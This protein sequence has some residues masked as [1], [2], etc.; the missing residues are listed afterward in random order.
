MNSHA[1]PAAGVAAAGRLLKILYFVLFG[2]VG[3]YWVV[4][5]FVAAG[6]EPREPGL[7]KNI[8][9][10]MGAAVGA[11]VVYLR[12]FLIPAALDAAAMEP[13]QRL[14]RLRLYYI[15]CFVLTEAVA[16]YGFLL[17]LLGG[18]PQDAAL[19]FLAAAGLFLLCYPRLPD[20]G[21]T[22]A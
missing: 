7:V 12:F 4:L 1:P 20:N 8:L 5:E 3:L 11:G 10:G 16:I 21:G 15:L 6:L 13:A 19:F 22:P 2:T 17:R 14:A 9:Q 18:A